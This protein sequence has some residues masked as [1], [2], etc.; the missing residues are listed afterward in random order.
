MRLW[1]CEIVGWDCEMGM[2]KRMRMGMEMG[3]YGGIGLGG[4]YYIIL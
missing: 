2:G 4:W 3:E 1:G